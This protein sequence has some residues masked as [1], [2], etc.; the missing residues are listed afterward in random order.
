M[1]DKRK[2]IFTA[3][4]TVTIKMWRPPARLLL[5]TLLAVHMTIGFSACDGTDAK[6]QSAVGGGR[7]V[8]AKTSSPTAGTDADGDRD[9]RNGQGYDP[10]DRE[11]FDFGR[12]ARTADVHAVS[13]VLRRYYEMA[14]A[15]EGRWACRL[16]YSLIAEQTVEEYMTSEQ[17]GSSNAGMDCAVVLSRLFKQRHAEL[18]RKAAVLRIKVVR[19]MG[20]R[21]VALIDVGALADH[22]IFV[23]R[24]R[25]A[26]KIY[27]LFDTELP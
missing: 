7:A 17:P 16:V 23:H 9:S 4:T 19:V 22:H 5:L 26:W 10:D 3:L 25:G 2:A 27:S 6:P 20:N 14:A 15:G 1:R 24:E 21:G 13:E 8:V 11:T 18:A 12:A